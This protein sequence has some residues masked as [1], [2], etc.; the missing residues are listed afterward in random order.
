MSDELEGVGEEANELTPDRRELP[1]TPW[2]RNVRWRARGRG[3]E[4]N[5]VRGA[6][7]EEDERGMEMRETVG[8]AGVF[9]F[10][11]YKRANSWVTANSR[12]IRSAA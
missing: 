2:T 9:E 7:G 3:F 11:R 1:Q 10:R 12:T 8:R 5:G 4:G 6:R